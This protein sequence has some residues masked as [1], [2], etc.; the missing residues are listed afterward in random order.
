M[1]ENSK[2]T[3]GVGALGLARAIYEYRRLGYTVSIPLVDAQDYDLVI[4][5]DNTFL[6]VQCRT[7]S[8]VSKDKKRYVAGLRTIKTN[9]KKTVTKNRGCYNL[10]FVFCENGDCYS[11]PSDCLPKTAV[12]LGIKYQKFKIGCTTTVG[13]EIGCNP[14][15]LSAKGFDSSYTHLWSSGE[16]GESH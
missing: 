8:Q 7:T 14:I 11:I 3:L 9:T 6:S 1:F 4:E 16:A 12:E 13:S 2:N 15:V 5:K 10:L